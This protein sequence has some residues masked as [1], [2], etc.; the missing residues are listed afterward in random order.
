MAARRQSSNISAARV[1]NIGTAHLFNQNVVV[2]TAAS[3]KVNELNDLLLQNSLVSKGMSMPPK[4]RHE[5]IEVCSPTTVKVAIKEASD[6]RL[7]IYSN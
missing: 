2:P 7:R 4:E 6:V 3:P 1:V 5:R